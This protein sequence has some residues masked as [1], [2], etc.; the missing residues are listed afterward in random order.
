MK[1]SF[2]KYVKRIM[3]IMLIIALRFFRV[4][5]L[6]YHLFNYSGILSVVPYV[7]SLSR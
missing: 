1:S 7:I 4:H 5:I 3:N 6:P 2:E